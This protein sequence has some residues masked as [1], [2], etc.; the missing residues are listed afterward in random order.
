MR[1][2]S[3]GA[4]RRSPKI[5]FRRPCVMPLSWQRNGSFRWPAHHNHLR[6]RLCGYPNISSSKLLG[7]CRV[8]SQQPGARTCAGG[9]LSATKSVVRFSARRSTLDRGR[10]KN[11]DPR[12]R[13]QIFAHPGTS[14]SDTISNR[15]GQLDLHEKIATANAK[16]LGRCEYCGRD[17]R[18]LIDA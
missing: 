16:S 6:R 18:E 11:S 14:E 7:D 3:S 4:T 13:S 5:P 17:R 8:S 10:V 15:M 1:K 2:I 9:R 12:L